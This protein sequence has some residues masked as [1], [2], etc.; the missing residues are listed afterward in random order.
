VKGAIE[1]SVLV[2]SV[3]TGLLETCPIGNV[4]GVKNLYKDVRNVDDVHEIE[5]KLSVL[6]S[7]AARVVSTILAATGTSSCNLVRK[8]LIDLRK[9]LFIMHFRSSRLSSEYF[10]ERSD[11]VHR[12]GLEWLQA[13]KKKHGLESETEMW[14]HTLRYY[15]DTPH[16]DLMQYGR[17][18]ELKYREKIMEM[19]KTRIDPGEEHFNAL[20]YYGLANGH[21]LCI[22]EVADGEEFVLGD[23]SFGLW[24]GTVAGHSGL[25]HLFVLSPR[26]IIVL[27][28][29]FL[30][31]EPFSVLSEETKDSFFST[32]M[33][34]KHVSP[35]PTYPSGA[36]KNEE[37]LA[38]IVAREE[39]M[40]K[41]KIVKLS[42]PQSREINII[43]LH[44]LPETGSVTFVSKTSMLRTLR[45][46]RSDFRSITGPGCGPLLRIISED[47]MKETDVGF[48]T[49]SEKPADFMLWVTATKVLS[50]ERA[51]RSQYD[52]AVVFFLLV[53]SMRPATGSL[54]EEYSRIL[55]SIMDGYHRC[56]DPLLLSAAV[57]Q[58]GELVRSL[59]KA[60]SDR[61]FQFME[62]WMRNLDVVK[63][64]IAMAVLM[65]ETAIIGF[66]DWLVKHQ[67]KFVMAMAVSAGLTV[68]ILEY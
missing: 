60:N 16:Q 54:Y 51:Y 30:R 10:K 2:Y 45:S 37:D 3:N 33:D 58:K 28:M 66:L 12:P 20:A 44:H 34:V 38:A 21:F 23:S 13:Y 64:E 22:W 63:S 46:F 62:K 17:E 52:R 24:E 41:F 15:L 18:I 27:S 56:S 14:L 50:G 49:E 9:F 25:H 31:P 53:K 43:M 57:P 59:P 32:L 40:F 4:Y 11:S 48:E 8:N 26:I 7:R 5:K 35:L 39:D 61:L 55:S 1:E 36:P 6:E 67:P 65:Y 29:Q 42:V 19:L 47:I 68:P